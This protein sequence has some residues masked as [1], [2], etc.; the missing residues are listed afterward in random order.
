LIIKQKSAELPLCA[1]LFAQ[2]CKAS[3]SLQFVCFTDICPSDFWTWLLLQGRRTDE[4]DFACSI[5]CCRVRAIRLRIAQSTYLKTFLA[6]HRSL[7]VVAPRHHDSGSPRA[8]FS[9]PMANGSAQE[10]R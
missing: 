2:H 5:R 6:T 10:L 8:T 4:E 3:R 9:S 7:F 1:H